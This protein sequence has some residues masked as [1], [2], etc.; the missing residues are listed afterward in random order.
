MERF[1]NKC[2][3]LVSGDGV[4]CPNCGEKLDS[5]VDLG[6]PST[7][8]SDVMPMAPTTT[9]N[10]TGTYGTTNTTNT[11]GVGSYQGQIPSYG[12]PVVQVTPVNNTEMT[13][14]QWVLTI[15]LSGLGIIGLILL[16]VWAFGS[17]TPTSK[18]NYARAMLIWQAIAVGLVIL[19][20][21][22]M[23][24]CIGAAAGG[25]SEFFNEI[26]NYAA[27]NNLFIR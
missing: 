12:Q 22:V 8:V 9:S 11:T 25:L 21:I 6:K 7:P 17:D 27:I 10:T 13:V 23:F 20:Y 24:A 14:G 5:A 4:F 18:K 2:G 1:C 19:F 26:E 15:F 3:S 16:F